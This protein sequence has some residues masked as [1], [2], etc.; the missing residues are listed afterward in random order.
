MSRHATITCIHHHFIHPGI[1]HPHIHALFLI[2]QLCGVE[3]RFN[4]PRGK[5]RIH[6]IL[7]TINI[8]GTIYEIVPLII[9]IQHQTLAYLLIAMLGRH[10]KVLVII[11]CAINTSTV[12][13]TSIT[14]IM[15][16]YHRQ[17]L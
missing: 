17:H 3:V 7:P 16:R 8:T 4:T 14:I 15:H 11:V 12:T 10:T 1:H 9:I 6:L 13:S 2:R 5:D